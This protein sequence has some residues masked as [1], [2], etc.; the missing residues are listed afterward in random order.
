MNNLGKATVKAE[1]LNGLS[2]IDKQATIYNFDVTAYQ[3]DIMAQSPFLVPLF[4]ERIADDMDNFAALFPSRRL[5]YI[6]NYIKYNDGTFLPPARTSTGGLPYIVW[7]ATSNKT[8]AVADEFTPTATVDVPNPYSNYDLIQPQKN[9]VYP[10]DYIGPKWEAARR[11]KEPPTND[12][13][14]I[15]QVLTMLGLTD[16]AATWTPDPPPSTPPYLYWV[17]QHYVGDGLW[18]GLESSPFLSSNMPFWIHLFLARSP[19]SATH[20]T[21]FYISI[22]L[23][24]DEQSFD[25]KLT[26]NTKPR[27]LDYYQGRNVVMTTGGSTSGTTG[28]PLVQK[29]FDVDLSRIWGEQTDIHIGFMTVAGRLVVWV[30]D[31][32]LVYTRIDKSD[33]DNNGKIKECRIGRGKIRVY[34]TNVQAMV[35]ASPMT[36]APM[37]IAAM[38]IVSTITSTNSEPIQ[39]T[40]KGVHYDGT[41]SGPVCILPQ[42]PTNPRNLYGVDCRYWADPAGSAIPSGVGFHNQG[43]LYFV[44]AADVGV[45]GIPDTSWYML[46]FRPENSSLILPDGTPSSVRYGGC[47]YFFRIKGAY[48]VPT[49][50]FIPE[51][52]LIPEVISATET[53]SA[54]DYF[55]ALTT[56]TVTIYNKG[57]KYDFLKTRQYGIQLS[58][59]W[60]TTELK[61]TFTGVITSAT[62]S[63]TPGKE[64][65]TLNCED[66]MFILKNTPIVNSPFYDGMVAYYAIADLAKRGG[67]KNF[68]NDFSSGSTNDYFLPSGYTFS[69]PA[70]RFPSKNMIFQCMMDIVKRFEAFIYFDEDG[71]LHIKKLPGG[72]FSSLTGSTFAGTF[73][74]NPNN[75]DVTQIELN[76]RNVE[77]NFSSTSNKI[78]ILTLDRDTRNAIVYTYSAG[79]VG[80]PPDHLLYRRVVMIDQPAYGD[81][82]V[83]RT[84]ARNLSKRIFWPIRKQNFATIGSSTIGGVPV[85]NKI[86]DFVKVDTLEFRITSIS[87]KYNAE[88]NDF[89]SEYGCEWLG[90]GP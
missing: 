67:I 6:D 3:Y 8:G 43:G 72:L 58:W 4:V 83:A 51:P 31:V 66:Y 2:G 88:S 12:A 63:E 11:P 68:V 64:T 60:S 27:I 85:V 75:S 46:I 10:S 25:L 32:P 62:S 55:H 30:N 70:M 41:M 28:V 34:G 53:A 15:R 40:Y 50:E 23:D 35:N 38:P 80:A 48:K 65:L 69:K 37:G 7:T 76:E 56:A 29:E 73:S 52:L 13:Q 33:G 61:K 42:P 84:Y 57:G 26:Q 49:Q 24:D 17:N 5:E 47:P 14:G 79:E 44:S 1:I 90:G 59:G 78:S 19:G 21:M 20:E 45:T 87:R 89:V 16:A 82:E 86:L 74:R 36:F 22:G 39:I 81:I 54:P 71:K 77:Y 9:Q 18:W